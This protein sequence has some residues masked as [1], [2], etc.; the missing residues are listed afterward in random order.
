M[1]SITLY[2]T[3]SNINFVLCLQEVGKKLVVLCENN[4]VFI[5]YVVNLH[6]N[7]IYGG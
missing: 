7:T 4:L 1:V 5:L 6:C 2:L 3:L